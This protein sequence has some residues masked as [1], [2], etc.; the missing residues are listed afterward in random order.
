MM[1]VAGLML[2]VALLGCH[3]LAGR[4]LFGVEYATEL[5]SDLRD[6]NWVNLLRLRVSQPVGE[7]LRLDFSSIGIARTRSERLIDD[8]QVF[9]NIEEAETPFALAVAGL[10]WSRGASRLFVGVRNLNEDYFTSPAA[11]F[12]TN[13]SCG[14][15]PTVSANY[16]IANYPLASLGLHYAF[17]TDR[18]EV[19]A[20]LYNGRGSRQLAGR[21]S[22]F[23]FC[24]GSDGV[25]GVVSSGFHDRT[26]CCCWG[27]ALYYAPRA[28]EWRGDG[29]G[30]V[31]GS[32]WG[33]VEQRLNS[34][35]TLLV[36]GS[37]AF[38]DRLRCRLFGGLGMMMQL[39]GAEI[40]LYSDCAVFSEGTEWASELTGRI[41]LSGSV[42]FQP[43]L[44]LIRGVSG[45]RAVAIL[46]LAIVL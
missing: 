10:T 22:V 43:A 1:R 2:A 45:F 13:S 18:W 21:G 16:P 9:S 12:F 20:S 19:Q 46:R 28:S 44:H 24:P 34:R 41:P 6:W 15:V 4:T 23:R 25:L 35:L 36:Q 14:I 32:F 38:P 30:A 17:A 42:H 40:G 31:S 37:L 8:L 7:R 29:A 33:Y 11:S 5:Q 27:G 39:R 26:G 3:R